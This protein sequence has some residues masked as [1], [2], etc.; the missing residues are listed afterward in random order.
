VMFH[1]KHCEWLY[2]CVV[3]Q[4]CA[5][6]CVW[7]LEFVMI[8]TEIPHPHL[9]ESNMLPHAAR[10]STRL[11]R[12]AAASGRRW[13]PELTSAATWSRGP[14]MR[15]CSGSCT[16]QGTTRIHDSQSPGMTQAETRMH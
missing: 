2:S 7:G 10:C 9:V 11:R 8:E 16:T 1:V 13:L 4:I 6:L 3:V 14:S 12:K 5:T 15:T